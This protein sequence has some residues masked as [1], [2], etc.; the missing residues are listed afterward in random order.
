[1][2]APFLFSI[3]DKIAEHCMKQ[4]SSECISKQL[5]CIALAKCQCNLWKCSTQLPYIFHSAHKKI[6]QDNQLMEIIFGNVL[7]NMTRQTSSSRPGLIFGSFAWLSAGLFLMKNSV[8]FPNDISTW[9]FWEIRHISMISPG[10][11]DTGGA[12][13]RQTS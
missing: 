4:Q 12:S 5:G 2:K 10:Q 6:A 7:R 8:I 1:M 13:V 11:S 3:F 9:S